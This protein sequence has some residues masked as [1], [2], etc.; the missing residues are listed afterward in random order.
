M[1]ED[2]RRQATE[3]YREHSASGEILTSDS[4]S[5]KK[6]VYVALAILVVVAVVIQT[7]GGFKERENPILK[8]ATPP[9]L[10]KEAPPPVTL[11]PSSKSAAADFGSR[12]PAPPAPAAKTQPPTAPA[13]AQPA[14]IEP[15]APAA[16]APAR[17]PKLIRETAPA[18]GA[19]AARSAVEPQA[20]AP[21]Q[22]SVAET[23]R[24]EGARQIVLEKSSALAKLITEQNDSAVY[25]GWKAEGDGAEAYRVTFTF[26]DATS[27]TPLQYVWKV[28]LASRT[29]QP[30]SYYSRKLP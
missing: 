2:L 5:M 12:A 9:P 26:L 10:V 25:R 21:A 22:S 19:P 13:A 24:Q 17:G 1:V 8:A 27:G 14:R 29:V 20:P 23:A 11:Q 3:L 16:A 7:F 4:L 28:N 15:R 18:A 30:L 6:L